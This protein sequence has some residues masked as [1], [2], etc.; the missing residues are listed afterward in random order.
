M[1]F[2]PTSNPIPT[3]P[4]EIY[5][6]PVVFAFTFVVEGVGLW[7]LP[8]ILNLDLKIKLIQSLT[9]ALFLNLATFL[10]GNYVLLPLLYPYSAPLPRILIDASALFP[11]VLILGIGFLLGLIWERT[12]SKRTR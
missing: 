10:L 6:I 7:Y 12:F 8:R 4:M 11:I 9:L 5:V 2:P 3:S 1:R